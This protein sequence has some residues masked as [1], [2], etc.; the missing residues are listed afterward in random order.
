[1]TNIPNQKP[2]TIRD[3]YPHMTDEEL[4]V[5]EENLKRYVAIIVRIH[6]RLKAENN[7]W[8]A[9]EPSET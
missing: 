2:I 7:E 4:V 9:A 3:L 8:P 5:A 1:M 6:E